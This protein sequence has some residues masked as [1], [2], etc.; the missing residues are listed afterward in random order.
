MHL[1][2]LTDLPTKHNQ[3]KQDCFRHYSISAV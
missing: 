2:T 3:V 1:S